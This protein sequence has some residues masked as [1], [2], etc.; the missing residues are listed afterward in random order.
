V[1]NEAKFKEIII[2]NY[3]ELL[4]RDPDLEGLNYHLR[5]LETKKI[6]PSELS[7]MIK[8]SKEYK[9]KNFFNS[10]KNLLLEKTM[11]EDWNKRAKIDIKYS[12]RS[13]ENQTDEDF[14]SSGIYD[15]DAILGKGPALKPHEYSDKRHKLLFKNNDPKQM[16]VLEIGCGLGRILIPM[17]KTFGN[18]FGVDVSDEMI[19]EC[20]KNIKKIPNCKIFKNNGMDLKMFSN[21]YFDLVY[22]FIVFQHIPDKSIIYEYFREISRILKPNGM[23]RIQLSGI[24]ENKDADTW[25][26]VGFTHDEIVLISKENLFDIIEESD[27]GTKYYWITMTKKV[28]S[29]PNDTLNYEVQVENLYQRI[30]LRQADKTGLFYFV[31]QLKS[32]KLS[33][34]EIEKSLLESDEGKKINSFSHYTDKYW[35][36]LEPVRQYKNQLSTGNKDIQWLSDI[37][38]RFQ[39]FLPFEKVLIVGCG[40]GWLERMLY[41][42]GIGKE[43]DAFDISEK[44][45]SEAKSEKGNRLINYFIDDINNLSKLESQKYDAIFNFAILHHATELEDAIKKLSSCLK[46]N[47]LIFNEE[48][49]GPA[50]NQY[51]DE[52]LQL[53]FEINS[54]LPEKFQTKQMLRPPLANFRVEPSEAIH[55]D[56]VIKYFKKYFD[57][58]YEKNMNGG[59]A[60]QILWNNIENFENQDPEA[61]KWLDYLLK[62]DEELT[63][64]GKVPV[65]FWYCVGSP[66]S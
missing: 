35:N 20:Q 11:E 38:D 63:N 60:Y 51:S 26:G 40:N 13:V 49:V 64:S 14:W 43:F 66:K 36:N 37:S 45:I 52:H 17:S 7:V 24:S 30:L 53:M 28:N 50:R 16:N 31:S 39:E 19:N 57:V 5:L 62:K 58:V 25:N 47:G 48:Y 65:M 33:L 44:Y 61:K 32:K 9:M 2:K 41:D 23:I 22:S 27:M 56:L 10:S 3:K 21:E 15:R 59:I 12:I 34:Q 29:I 54:D 42:N 55:S 18:V 8:N 1:S 46:P 6:I 4:G